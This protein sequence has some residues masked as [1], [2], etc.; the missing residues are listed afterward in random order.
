MVSPD[1]NNLLESEDL[2]VKAVHDKV[3]NVK[4][5]LGKVTKQEIKIKGAAQKKANAG[6][7]MVNNIKMAIRTH[8]HAKKRLSHYEEIKN[9]TL[10][11]IILPTITEELQIIKRKYDNKQIY[12]IKR[13]Q[14]IQQFFDNK[15]EAFIFARKHLKNL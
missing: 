5:Q 1:L 15:R 11:N 9:N 3:D 8:Q 2:M 10:N 14:Y 12:S 4:K 7:D 6:L 13:Q